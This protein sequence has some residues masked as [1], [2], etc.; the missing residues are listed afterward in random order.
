MTLLH[1]VQGRR[2]ENI[3]GAPQFFVADSCFP[4]TIE[5]VKGRAE[6]L[7]IELVFGDPLNARFDD[8]VFGILVQS[9]DEAGLVHDLRPVLERAKA[10]GV[11][12]AVAT[13]LLS[14]TLLKPAG[15]IGADVVL[16]NSQRDRKST[17]LNSSHL[18]I[19]YAVFRL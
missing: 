3:V 4:Q 2:I 15:E 14:L 16:G 6:P 17:R 1:R 11:M 8:R 9:P 10:A 13:D 5:V 19:S 18:G 12:V 7:G